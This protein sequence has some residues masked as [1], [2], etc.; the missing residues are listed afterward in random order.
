MIISRLQYGL[1]NQLFQYALGK[2]LAQD[3]NRELK[4]DLTWYHNHDRNEK[5]KL[6]KRKFLLDQYS[7]EYEIITGLQLRRHLPFFGLLKGKGLRFYRHQFRDHF[8]KQGNLEVWTYG[9]DYHAIL[10]EAKR[11]LT[12][13]IYVV[14]FLLDHKVINP[15]RKDLIS[16]LV[17]GKVTEK[18][19]ALLNTIKSRNS[20]FVHIRRGD[21]VNKRKDDLYVCDLEYYQKAIELIRNKLDQPY[22]VYFTDEPDF[23]KKWFDVDNGFLSTEYQNEPYFDLDLMK[24]CSHAILSNSTFSWW[25]AYLIDNKDVQVI[26]P[27]VWNKKDPHI[28]EQLIPDNWTRI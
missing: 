21:F 17:P 18:H 1:G 4:L 10:R 15:I 3:T 23:V 22:F 12:P 16:E 9:G 26:C 8:V 25:G 6:T 7:L 2:R 27:A 5:S 24:N 13:S 14:G 28:S 20:V 11:I 19:K